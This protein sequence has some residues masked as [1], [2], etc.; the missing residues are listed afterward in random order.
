MTE[1]EWLARNDVRQAADAALLADTIGRLASRIRIESILPLCQLLRDIF[2]PCR[3][4][5]IDP[6]WQT[7]QVV[8]LAQAAYDQRE[9]PAGHLD[10]TRLAVLADALE[11]AGCDQADI[12]G[13]LRGH[14]PHVRGR[15]AVDLILGNS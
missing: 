12:L 4:V 5:T 3:P 2:N 10:V 7:A 14:G 8:A 1:P 13:H 11:D 15:W 6:A 9:L